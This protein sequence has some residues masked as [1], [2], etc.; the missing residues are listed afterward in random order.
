MI[1]IG[2]V[3]K[4]VCTHPVTMWN[5]QFLREHDETCQDLNSRIPQK[6]NHGVDAPL[7]IGI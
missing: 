1:W 2:L 4:Y 5:E 6:K 3:A 7:Y